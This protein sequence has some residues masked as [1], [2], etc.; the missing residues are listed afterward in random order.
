MENIVM[1]DCIFKEYGMQKLSTPKHSQI[2][3]QL[4]NK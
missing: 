4:G 2:P 3:E 1:M